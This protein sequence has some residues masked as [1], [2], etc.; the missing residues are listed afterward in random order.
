MDLNNHDTTSYELLRPLE[1]SSYGAVKRLG[2]RIVI[3]LGRDEDALRATFRRAAKEIIEQ[4]RPDALFIFG[5]RPGDSTDGH[6][7]V[8]RLTYAANGKWEDARLKGPVQVAIELGSLYFAQ[9]LPPEDSV[10]GQ[11]WRVT[12]TGRPAVMSDAYGAWGDENVVARLPAGSVVT[13]LSR[14]SEPFTAEYEFVRYRVQADFEGATVEGWMHAS[15]LKWEGEHTEEPYR[16]SN[17][18]DLSG[19]RGD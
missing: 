15:D 18:Q 4:E 17:D 13:I 8:G 3:P 9:P 7:S 16:N 11:V 19:E 2:A 14:K 6:Y 1:D 5:F 10:R 12:P